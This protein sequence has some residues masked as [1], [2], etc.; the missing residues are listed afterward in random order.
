MANNRAVRKR[1]RHKWRGDPSWGWTA[2]ELSKR[3]GEWNA[4]EKE[5]GTKREKRLFDIQWKEK[6]SSKKA[7]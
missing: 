3:G 2:L 5:G 4:P 7:R 1:K 6:V